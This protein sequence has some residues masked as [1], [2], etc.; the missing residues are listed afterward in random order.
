MFHGTRQ[1][2]PEVIYS[3]EYSLDN[4]LASEACLYGRGIYFADNSQYSCGYKYILPQDPFNNPNF[5]NGR[6]QIFY[7]FVIVGETIQL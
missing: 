1:I 2:N 6:F 7:C 3:G 4:R 5:I